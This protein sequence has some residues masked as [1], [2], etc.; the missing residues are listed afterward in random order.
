MQIV[1]KL[2]S[3]DVAPSEPSN[4]YIMSEPTNSYLFGRPFEKPIKSKKLGSIFNRD[5]PYM[6]LEELIKKKSTPASMSLENGQI[7]KISMSK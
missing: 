5:V 7:T 1:L 3:G 6:N 2:I 4:P